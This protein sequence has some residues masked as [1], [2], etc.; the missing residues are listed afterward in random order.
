MKDYSKLWFSNIL[1]IIDISYINSFIKLEYI[2]KI[3]DSIFLIKRIKM[4]ISVFNTPWGTLVC[5][6]KQINYPICLYLYETEI[7]LSWPKKYK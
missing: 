5:Y 1:V 4:K 7:Q 2:E 6:P 3:K